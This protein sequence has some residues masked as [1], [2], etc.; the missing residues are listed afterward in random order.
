MI[1]TIYKLIQTRWSLYLIFAVS[2]GLYANT[3]FHE[4]VLDDRVVFTENKFVQEGFNG[5]GKIFS[6]ETFAGY[7][8]DSG[9]KSTV[10]GGR[11]RPL[12]LS[13]FAVQHQLF[14]NNAMTAH[15]LNILFFG[16]LNCIIFITLAKLLSFKYPNNGR[17]IAIVSTL[18]FA[19]HPIHTEV[20]ANVKGLDEIWSLL[21][22][23]MSLYFL[24]K[25][26]E[27]YKWS[28]LFLSGFFFLLAL[29]SKE[30]SIV[31]LFLIPL[32]IGLFI[33]QTIKR[34]WLSYS[35]LLIS[36]AVFIG[37]R[38]A[39]L[40]LNVISSSRNFLENPFLQYRGERL[41]DMNPAEKYGTIFYSL[42]RYVYLQF[43]PYPLTHDYAPKSIASYNLFS[44]LPL[45]AVL[46]A[47]ASMFLA[48]KWY[49]TKPIYSWSI[50]LFIL[51]LIPTSNLFFSIGAYMGERFVFVSSLGFCL[52]LAAFFIKFLQPKYNW[53]LY[54]LMVILIAFSA[55][56]VARNTVWKSNFT[57]FNNDYQHSSNSAKLNSSLGF[58][59][60]EAYRNS[61]DK[62]SNKHLVTQAIFHLK[63]ALEIYPNYLDC[64]FLLGNAYY[65]VKDHKNAVAN[66]EKYITLN[67]A[68]M[69]IMKNYQKSLREYGRYLF[70]EEHNN[71]EAKQV[72]I[73][74]LKLNPND[75]QALEL[76]G[77]AEA[78]LGYLLKSLE[79]LNKASQ[80]NPNSASVWANLY[81]T[82]TR[83][84]DKPAAQIAINKGM[85][86][87]KDVV[88]KLMTVKTK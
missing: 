71:Q 2:F 28:N 66:Y 67:P 16:L 26:S 5:I 14:G 63:K 10:G 46:L 7:F 69:S 42:I 62:E 58:T 47:S 50:L 9:R 36:A 15:L 4:F 20:V 44:P 40:G 86:I 17:L 8:K 87:D 64:I 73:K 13:F 34:S 49:K 52:M 19:V 56:T 82:L 29:F 75:D 39:V 48:I 81:I 27:H 60:L 84:G 1:E 6:N 65:L 37:I 43:I 3:L 32:A 85:A 51:S 72:L 45:L 35:P 88:K 23:T 25:N 54:L 55:R 83:I 70:H 21:F 74:S 30:N 11:Y 79:Y 53:S 33:P 80:I 38:I 57:L 24:I 61:N 59:L 18:L 12:S 22:S 76:L 41:L 68:D 77:S 78:E 31:F